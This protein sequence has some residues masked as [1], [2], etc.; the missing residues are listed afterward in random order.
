[1]PTT[2][3]TIRIGVDTGGTFTDV[4]LV[5]GTGEKLLTTKV[6]STPQD[7]SK[8]VLQ[9]VSQLVREL[10]QEMDVSSLEMEVIHG[11]TV[12][13]NAILEG[14]GAATA[15][16]TTQGFEDTLHL[17]R[18]TRPALYDLYVQATPSPIPSAHCLGVPERISAHGEVLTPLP[19]GSMEELA[20]HIARLGFHSIAISLLHSYANPAHEQAL[21]RFLRKRFPHISVTLSHELLPEFREYERATTCVINALVAPKMNAY[22]QH[23]ERE[24]S[25]TLLG[26]DPSKGEKLA[27]SLRI[28]SSTG[29]SLPVS[30]IQKQPIHTILSG[31]A[32]EYLVPNMW[33]RRL[34]SRTSSR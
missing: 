6:L 21:G 9:G 25:P 5:V 13:T 29:G 3:K 17:A 32:G 15:F 7:P 28:L 16:I 11:S 4:V 19:L 22:L 20:S 26:I 1:M 2:H 34:A 24:L 27:V 33:D 10:F 30:V 31:P 23:L 8:A 12:A 18:Q 14:K